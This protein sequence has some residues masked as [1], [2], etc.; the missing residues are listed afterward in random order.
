[1]DTL[2]PTEIPSAAKFAGKVCVRRKAGLVVIC[3][4]CHGS[5]QAIDR[6][7]SPESNAVHHG[8]ADAQ[9]HSEVASRN[10]L[11]HAGCD[12]RGSQI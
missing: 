6:Q 1:L 8:F 9:R 3:T 4:D 10:I 7:S 11:P 12:L 2:P 5:G